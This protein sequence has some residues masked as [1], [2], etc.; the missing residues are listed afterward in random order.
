MIKL[1]THQYPTPKDIA[2]T[3]DFALDIL[4]NN[5]T[6]LKSEADLLKSFNFRDLKSFSFNSDG[7]LS[8]LCHLGL[9]GKIAISVGETEALYE[10]GKL[11]ESLG[12]DIVWIGLQ[13]DGHVDINCI[14]NSNLDFIFISSYTVD[15]YV[16]NDL[17]SIKKIS[18]GKIISNGSLDISKKSDALYFDPYKLSGFAISGIILSNSL[19]EEQPIGYKDN[20]SVVVIKELLERKTPFNISL[21]HKFKDIL[22]K[23]FGDDI[24]LFVDSNETLEYT[25]HFGLK[26]IKARELI[27]TLALDE[28]LITNGEGCSL[29]LSKP[30]R[31]IQKMGYTQ[32]QSRNAISISFSEDM[33]EAEMIQVVEL[34]F[35]RYKQIRILND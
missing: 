2:V 30:S 20:L 6:Y 16:K 17:E 5:D 25:L 10:A 8:L 32:D 19:F 22:F 13:K 24:Y 1:N 35:K 29:G 11:Y 28:I 9:Q 12:F 3:T 27:R 18:N 14:K 21:K 4:K 34:M 7:F 31:V 33:T 23:T 26:S 15:T